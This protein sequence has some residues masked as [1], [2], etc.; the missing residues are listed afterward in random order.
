MEGATTPWLEWSV[1]M[2]P[3]DGETLCGDAFRAFGPDERA[4]FAMV[5][6]AGHGPEASH[7]AEQALTAIEHAL[8]PDGTGALDRVMH[9]CHAALA[10]TRGASVALLQI[11]APL[12]RAAF[13]GV[14]NI[15]LHVYPPRRHGGI[16]FPG[17]VGYRLPTVR[18]FD[19]ELA[20][21]DVW[22]MSTD[23]LSSH[24][25]IDRYRDDPA[26]FVA[27]R[28]LADFGRRTDDATAAAIRVLSAGPRG[29]R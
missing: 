15:A 1:A 18:V 19:L 17:T 11:C 29:G 14:G 12:G 3:I 24:V 21:G 4:T 10:R 23:G 26:A 28:A 27:R 7:A 6:G 2:R 8:G 20:R 5:D 13:S 22:L 16:S 9:A 25:S